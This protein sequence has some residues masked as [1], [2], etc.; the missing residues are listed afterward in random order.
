MKAEYTGNP[1][2]NFYGLDLVTG[3][4]YDIPKNLESKIRANPNFKVKRGN[5]SASKKQGT[6]EA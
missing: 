6:E 4:V 1:V 2:Q 5:K 3:E